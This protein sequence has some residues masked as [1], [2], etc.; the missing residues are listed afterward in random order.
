M[1][2]LHKKLAHLTPEQ[3]ED[4]VKRYN[5]DEKLTSLIEAFNINANPRGLVHLLPPVLHKDLLCPYCPITNLISKRPARTFEPRCPESPRCPGCGHRHADWCPCKPCREK[6][7]AERR[8][9]D[10]MKRQVIEATYTR[11]HHI[12]PPE[13]LTLQ[14]A[15]FLLAVKRHAATDDLGYLKPY[16]A[17]KAALAPLPE[18]VWHILLHLYKS[19]L[20]AISLDS[21]VHAF[22]FDQAVTEIKYHEPTRVLWAFMPGLERQSKRE[23]LN[24]LKTLVSWGDWPD[25]WSRDVPALWHFIVKY[26]CLQLFVY[27]LA[28]RGCKQNPIDQKTLALFDSLLVDFPPSKI[29][30][31]CWQGATKT[32]D[33]FAKKYRPHWKSKELFIGAIQR[34][35][36]LAMAK[37]WELRH[38]DRNYHCPQTDVSAT[39]FYDFLAL[40]NMA[41][42]TVPPRWD[43]SCSG[44]INIA[45]NDSQAAD[46][47]GPGQ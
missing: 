16:H 29:F 15:V 14:D 30:N 42:K 4:L 13:N 40:G 45:Q 2:A 37:G 32:K 3:V 44:T 33:D 5:G 21:H 36:D 18:C 1:M 12:P 8:E 17:Y 25:G 28:K 34:R 19:G 41:N 39:F 26:E 20:I 35:A 7:E 11:E 47:P 31:L 24:R 23:Y 46:S 9:S 27:L 22:E 6:A 38:F 10:K 43:R